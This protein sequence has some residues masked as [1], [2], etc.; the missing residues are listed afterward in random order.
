MK[1][2]I[3]GIGHSLTNSSNNDN[4]FNFKFELQLGSDEVDE[5]D[6]FG[7]FNKRL[8]FDSSRQRYHINYDFN[9]TVKYISIPTE[10]EGFLLKKRL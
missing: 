5:N 7:F 2:E 8:Y 4:I 10:R 6:T 1:Y 3:K 9:Q